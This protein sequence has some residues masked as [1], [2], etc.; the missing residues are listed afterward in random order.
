MSTVSV[1]KLKVRRGLD[2]ERL[3]ITLDQGELGYTTDSQ[4]LFVGD[5]FTPGGLPTG[6]M[7]YTATKSITAAVIGD[8]VDKIYTIQT[9][10]IVFDSLYPTTGMYILTGS[11]TFFNKLSAYCKLK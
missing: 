11:N 4:R 3:Q 7:Y 8:T 6:I 5:A 9:G 2:S 10:D 1:V